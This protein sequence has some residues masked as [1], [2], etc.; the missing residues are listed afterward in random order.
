[1]SSQS[2]FFDQVANLVTDA[3]GLASHMRREIETIVKA[4]LERA[5][6]SLNLVSREEHEV[7]KEMVQRLAQENEALAA[8]VR[9]LEVAEQK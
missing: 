7:L 5:A 4:Q 9:A 6:G 3:A 8:R 1:M 2:P